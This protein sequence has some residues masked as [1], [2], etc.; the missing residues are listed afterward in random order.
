MPVRIE[1]AL[2]SNKP[3]LKL[4]ILVRCHSSGPLKDPWLKVN[5]KTVVTIQMLIII[6]RQVQTEVFE[7]NAQPTLNGD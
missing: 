4:L 6:P 3:S 5:P 7:F 1:Y 2:D